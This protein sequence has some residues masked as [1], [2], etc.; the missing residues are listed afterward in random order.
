MSIT[1]RVEFGGPDGSRR[2]AS[3]VAGLGAIWV[4]AADRQI[5]SWLTRIDPATGTVDRT[6]ALPDRMAPA[7]LALG[8]DGTLLAAGPFGPTLAGTVAPSGIVARIDPATGQVTAQ[9]EVAVQRG[10]AA[11]HGAVWVSAGSS[12]IRLD[13]ASLQVAATYPVSGIPDTACGLTVTERT[14]VTALRFLDPLT[15]SVTS[16]IDLGVGGGLLGDDPIDDGQSCVALGGPAAGSD[17]SASLS[18][19]DT[20]GAEPSMMVAW[21][22]PGFR[23]EVRFAGGVFWLIEDGAMTPVDPYSLAPLGATWRLPPEVGDLSSWTLLG[24]SGTMWWVGPTEALRIGVAVPPMQALGRVTSEPWS[25]PFV[26]RSVTF[27]GTKNG[28]LVGATGS[29]AGAG[30]VATTDD[31]GRTWVQRLLESPPLTSVT[32]RGPLLIAMA[33]CRFDA[34]HGCQP[35][36]LRSTDGGLDWVASGG[37][38]IDAVELAPSGSA[39]AIEATGDGIA[40]SRDGGLT[41]QHRPSPCPPG[42]PAFRPSDISNPT[43]SDVWLTCAGGGAMGS[44]DK[45]LLRSTDGGAKWHT[46]FE[47][48]LTGGGGP[49]ELLGGNASRID[50]LADGTGWLWTGYGLYG[51]R[52]GGGTWRL[53][54]FQ[55]GSGALFM[56]GMHLD[57]ATSGEVLIADVSGSGGVTL[58]RTVDGGT[59]WT[60]INRWPL[61]Q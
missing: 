36:L 54:G 39:W 21:R 35:T 59:T 33:A 2:A 17:A 49:Q 13:P 51:T 22:S 24:V 1:A 29:G 40:V 31:G 7:E 6:S 19:L 34:P 4:S 53:L 37:P 46:V 57:S 56:D 48:T 44:S 50:F 25:G 11:A 9:A 16:T 61:N 5:G 47:T 12:L 28:V 41:W 26:P 18:T 60:T 30:V 52:D 8:A 27:D 32:E 14:G 20:L 3:S 45:A 15:G 58:Q 55:E 42:T 38:G 43:A 10:I 23:G